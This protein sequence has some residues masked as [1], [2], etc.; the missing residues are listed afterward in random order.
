MT[1]GEL[2]ELLRDLPDSRLVVVVKNSGA[3]EYSPLDSVDAESWYTPETTWSGQLHHSSDVADGEVELTD[4][5]VQVAVL[6]PVH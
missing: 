3:D 5:S 1:V 4:K 2:K 6:W